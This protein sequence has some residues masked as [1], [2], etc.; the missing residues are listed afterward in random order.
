[1]IL[2]IVNVIRID[3]FSILLKG[4]L[5]GNAYFSDLDLAVLGLSNSLYL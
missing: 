2:L 5:T 3:I 1:M 4:L